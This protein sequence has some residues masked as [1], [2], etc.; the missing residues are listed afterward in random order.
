MPA[1]LS[2]EVGAGARCRFGRGRKALRSLLGVSQSEIARWRRRPAQD[3][4]GEIQSQINGYDGFCSL[5]R[6]EVT[7]R[8][9]LLLQILQA[10]SLIIKSKSPPYLRYRPFDDHLITGDIE[11]LDPRCLHSHD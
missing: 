8:L 5:Y 1:K 10:V 4:F 2:G 9:S 6:I 3:S 7:S 11:A